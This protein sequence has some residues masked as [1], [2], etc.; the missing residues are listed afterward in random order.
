L[1]QPHAARSLV[2]VEETKEQIG[3]AVG[4]IRRFLHAHRPRAAA[5]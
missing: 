4:Q 1:L 5:E 2:S 3:Q